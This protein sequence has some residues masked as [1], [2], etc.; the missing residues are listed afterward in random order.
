MLPIGD[1]SRIDRDKFPVLDLNRQR[2]NGP[3]SIFLMGNRTG[4]ACKFLFSK[5]IHQLLPIQGTCCFNGVLERLVR[6]KSNG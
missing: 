2:D 5:G 3:R 1:I 4:D 6:K